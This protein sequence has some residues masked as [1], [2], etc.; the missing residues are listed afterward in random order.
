[1]P[2][3]HIIIDDMQAEIDRLKQENL[4]L[5]IAND[6]LTRVNAQMVTLA[7]VADRHIAELTAQLAE[8][9]R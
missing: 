5:R 3:H 8:A 6:R 7:K 1:M 9:G 4:D 2:T